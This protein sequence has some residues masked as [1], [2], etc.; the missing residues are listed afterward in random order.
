MKI[1]FRW[2]L[3]ALAVLPLLPV[4]GSVFAAPAGVPQQMMPSYVP[5]SPSRGVASFRPR[6][7]AQPVRPMARFAPPG[8][9]P[10]SHAP[11]RRVGNWPLPVSYRPMMPPP[12]A[13]PPYGYG[14]QAP[15]WAGYRPP[16]RSYGVRPASQPVYRYPARPPV[17]V[18]GY[19]QAG[20]FRP[21]P[22]YPPMTP[23][24]YRPPGWAMP[25]RTFMPRPY[26]SNPR[27]HAYPVRSMPAPRAHPGRFAGRYQPYSRGPGGRPDYQF[28][29]MPQPVAYRP[30]PMPGRYGAM[31]GRYGAAR[32]A[33][34]D[35]RA[36]PL[37]R[38]RA[39]I[40]HPAGAY[41]ARQMPDRPISRGELLAW[42]STAQRLPG[43]T[44]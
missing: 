18:R 17:G 20:Q 16:V 37:P 13:V 6:Y 21:R 38:Q 11:V 35:Y 9:I 7:R 3:T 32:L 8:N 2:I 34:P 41:Q 15:R 43:A 31:P 40:R 19:P 5:A 27:R 4:A 24:G 42:R 29:P 23:V 33:P 28:R 14:R 36:L 12:R 25:G 10:P 1:R 22:P 39:P 44:H 26:N 30:Y